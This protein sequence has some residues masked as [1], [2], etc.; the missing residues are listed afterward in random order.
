MKSAGKPHRCEER[1]ETSTAK[2]EIINHAPKRTFVC[3]LIS[4]TIMSGDF[5]GI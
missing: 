3:K 5:P 1:G 2:L 4:V